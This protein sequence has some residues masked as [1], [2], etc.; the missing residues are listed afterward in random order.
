MDRDRSD[1]SA[2]AE[3]LRGPGLICGLAGALL[4]GSVGVSP[5]A[6]VTLVPARDNTLF[7]SNAGEL[8]SGSGPAL[9]VGNTGQGLRRRAVLFFDVA[10]HV[11]PGARVDSVVLTLQV[12]N[13]PNATLRQTTLHRVFAEWGEGASE[14]S[15]GGGVDAAVG[16][17][18]WIH[19]FY[20]DRSWS[21]PGGEFEPAP[22]AA[23]LVGPEGAHRW[24]GPGPVADVQ[25]WLTQPGTNH[26]WLMRGEETTPNTARRFESR[27]AADP[28]ARPSLTI[29]YS[30][31]ST[32]RSVTWGSLKV[33][34]R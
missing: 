29:H 14:A 9:F 24:S 18:T 11:P 13:A 26:G 2:F 4:I 33:R 3:T 28:T 10:S 6:T 34:Y 30:R 8:G 31:T 32:A 16:D 23:L 17:A 1:R 20:P 25:S 12:S 21:T 19:A 5:A 15:G 27:E 22:S 7:E